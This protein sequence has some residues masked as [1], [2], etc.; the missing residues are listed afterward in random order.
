MTKKD[1]IMTL[2]EKTSLTKKDAER[3]LNAFFETIEESMAR[4]EEVSFT[5]FGKFEVRERAERTARNPRT[6]EEI[7]VPAK[8]VVVFK[9]G[10]TLQEKAE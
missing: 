7:K 10:K 6:G 2:S 9:V 1:V 4:G 3:A 5:G 8:K